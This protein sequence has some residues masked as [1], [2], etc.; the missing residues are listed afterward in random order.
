MES[1]FGVVQ[2]DGSY[3]GT[4]Q[5]FRVGGQQ[6]VSASGEINAYDKADAFKVQRELMQAHASGAIGTVKRRFDLNTEAAGMQLLAGLAAPAQ[7]RLADA[8]VALDLNERPNEDVIAKDT[9]VQVGGLVNNDIF[10]TNDV[11]YA[12]ITKLR[13]S[14]S[15]SGLARIC[16]VLCWLAE[17]K[18]VSLMCCIPWR[19]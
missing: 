12:G 6:L 16:K 14:S 1:I 7:M 8:G 17:W 19:S 18:V 9:V 10:T 11:T 15:H 2:S 4:I 13:H 5:D 3:S